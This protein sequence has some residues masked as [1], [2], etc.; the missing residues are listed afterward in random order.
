MSSQDWCNTGNDQE[1]STGS[2]KTN[3]SNNST[4]IPDQDLSNQIHNQDKR[5]Q[6]NQRNTVEININIPKLLAPKQL[7]DMILSL[8]DNG[9]RGD[10]LLDYLWKAITPDD[11]ISLPVIR[12]QRF[13]QWF[14]DTID[15]A[16]VN[17]KFQ[18]HHQQTLVVTRLLRTSWPENVLE[19]CT[20]FGK[21]KRLAAI[22]ARNLNPM[23]RLD[24]PTTRAASEKNNPNGR[25]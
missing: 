12:H 13:C 16:E 24:Y 10:E 18:E 4:N 1:S 8:V 11:F 14:R 19:I 3:S 21:N 20:Q 23:D 9:F 17:T 15:L 22:T 25:G 2:T 5:D 7:G 6:D